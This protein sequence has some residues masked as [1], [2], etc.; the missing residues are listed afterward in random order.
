M[1]TTTV[2]T[3]ASKGSALTH[4]EMDSNWNNLLGAT[5]YVGSIV[6]WPGS[7]AP[8]SK[9]LE[10]AGQSLATASYPDL[11]SLIGYSYGGSGSVFSL[12]DLRGQFV[13]GWNHGAST[14]PDV[15]SRTDRGDGT[16]G[17][18]VG[19]KQAGQNQS[20]THFTTTS[21]GSINNPSGSPVSAS[22]RISRLGS[23]GGDFAYHLAGNP[24]T[25]DVGLTSS[26]GGN[27]S[28]PTN[29]QLMY[30]IKVLK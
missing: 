19:T 26:N 16:T 10:C 13:R 3:R 20:H 22:N 29:I 9:W 11:F 23:T 12:P 2:T 17:D 30:L 6:I 18:S 28:R 25:A 14:D 15:A 7:S 1:P 27:E 5:V 21:D 24:N 8:D 4:G